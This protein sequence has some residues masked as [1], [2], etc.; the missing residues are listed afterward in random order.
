MNFAEV[1]GVGWECTNTRNETIQERERTRASTEDP[2][3]RTARENTKHI[4]GLDLAGYNGT[5]TQSATTEGSPPNIGK[6]PNP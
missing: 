2:N 1:S 4:T 5:R 3:S 6:L